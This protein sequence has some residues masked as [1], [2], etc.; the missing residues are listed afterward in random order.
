MNRGWIVQLLGSIPLSA[1]LICY[2]KRQNCGVGPMSMKKK[3]RGTKILSH[4][5]LKKMQKNLNEVL[6]P[7]PHLRIGKVIHRILAYSGTLSQVV[8][9]TNVLWGER[10]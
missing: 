7:Q 5:S 8:T 4:G 2:T 1:I 10:H 9:V 3:W 6:L